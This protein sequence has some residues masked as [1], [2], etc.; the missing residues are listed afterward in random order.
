MGRPPAASRLN[1]RGRLAGSGMPYGVIGGR[2]VSRLILG[3]NTPGAHS[4]DLL[5]VSQLGRAYNTKARMLDMF[6]QAEAQGINT[7]LQG[8]AGL[9]REY[10]RTRGGRL[11]TIQPRLLKKHTCNSFDK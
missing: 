2:K 3:S 6:A 9:I 7:V 11:R 1:G 4:R 5:Y 10:N 8:N